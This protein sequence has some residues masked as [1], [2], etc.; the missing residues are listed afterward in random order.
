MC[1][2]D[3]EYSVKL[4]LTSSILETECQMTWKIN[5]FLNVTHNTLEF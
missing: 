3:F 5:V 2:D 1:S 4:N